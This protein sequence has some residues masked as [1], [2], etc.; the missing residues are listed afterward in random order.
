MDAELTD[1]VATGLPLYEAF[2]QCAHHPYIA[3]LLAGTA[4]REYQAHLIPRGGPPGLECLYGDGVLLAGDA[5]KINTRLGV[6]SWPAMASGAAAA[7]AVTH[8]CEA[9]DFSRDALAV[10][11]DFLTN[12]G[13]AAMIADARR[14]WTGEQVDLF[15]QV[16]ADPEA[17]YRFFWRW[18]E[19]E[20]QVWPGADAPLWV[21]G[22]RD[23]LRPIAS[24]ELRDA[25]DPVAELEA[26]RWRAQR[27]RDM[28]KGESL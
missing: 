21:Q 25:L 24:D 10:Y 26:R 19:E 8:A 23:L 4:L 9:G 6:G 17:T 15:D 5:G 1:L 20:G 27:D 7:R 14:A 2:E 12:E 28:G 22:Y 13:V 16:A 18:Q 3:T 11:A